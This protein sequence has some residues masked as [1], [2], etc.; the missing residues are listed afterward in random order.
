MVCT[1][2]HKSGSKEYTGTALVNFLELFYVRWPSFRLGSDPD[3]AG[4]DKPDL[5]QE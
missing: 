4:L 5:D 2:L 1:V 3:L